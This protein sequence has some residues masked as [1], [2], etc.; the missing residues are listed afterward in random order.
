MAA[1]T[2][3]AIASLALAGVGTGLAVYGQVQQAENAKAVGKY[4]AR[5][6]EAQ[7]KQTEMDA[8]ENIRRKRKEN[9][10]ILATQRSKYAK[11][12]VIEAGTPLELMA[13]TA[14]NLELDV[15]DYNRQQRINAQNLRQQGAMDLAM[16]QNAAQAG[17]INAGATLLQGAGQ[18]AG[19]AAMAPR[20]PAGAGPNTAAGMQAA[21]APTALSVRSGL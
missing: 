5:L 7:A 19:M 17:Y 9:A 4:N 12:G 11:A 10:R 14:G 18:A 21:G 8:A 1:A 15:L 6:A 16:G 3:L 20:A 13:E 2:S